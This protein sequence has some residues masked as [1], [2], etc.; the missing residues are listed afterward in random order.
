MQPI[1]IDYKGYTITTDKSQMIVKDIH[2]WLSTEA[3]WCKNIPLDVVQTAFDNSFCIGIL[4]DGKQVG[5]ARFITDYA[6]FAY[7]ADVY[8][9]E[10]HRGIG[11]SKKMMDILMNLDWMNGLR[12]IKLATLDAHGLYEQFGFKKSLS[13]SDRNMEIIRPNVYGDNNNPCT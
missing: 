3:Y 13:E 12:V 2:Q 8:V 10:P 6:I 7:L 11:L 4:K 1:T 9:E 5:Y